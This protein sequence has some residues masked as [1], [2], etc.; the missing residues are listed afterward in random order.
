MRH[1]IRINNVTHKHTTVISPPCRSQ[2]SINT[3]VPIT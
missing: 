3:T 2:R 1:S